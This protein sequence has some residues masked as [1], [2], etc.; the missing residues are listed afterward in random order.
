[1]NTVCLVG[2]LT[3]DPE[4]KRTQNGL[5]FTKGSTA[6]AKN[7]L[8]ILSTCR[9]GEEQRNLSASTSSKDSVSA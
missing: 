4:L 7:R 6:R 3:A 1:M 2:R 5:A 8:P 9:H